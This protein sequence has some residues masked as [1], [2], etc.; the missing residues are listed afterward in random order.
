MGG[1]PDPTPRTHVIQGLVTL[2]GQ[3][4]KVSSGGLREAGVYINQPLNSLCTPPHAGH[5]SDSRG[6]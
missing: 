4:G 1:H 6:R 5:D 2:G 3:V